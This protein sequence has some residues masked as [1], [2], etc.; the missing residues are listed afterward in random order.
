M[1]DEYDTQDWHQFTFAF[2]LVIGN[3]GRPDVRAYFEQRGILSEEFDS[4][5]EI[6]KTLANA[7][8]RDP[9]L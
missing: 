2:G 9:T 7:F 1:G 8:Y 6:G 5:R 4:F 3:M